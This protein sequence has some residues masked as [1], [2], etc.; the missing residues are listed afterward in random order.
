MIKFIRDY[1]GKAT[2]ERFFVAG[3][4]T[5]EFNAET[6]KYLIEVEAAEKVTPKKSTAKKN[7][8]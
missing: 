6:E 1:R 8:D 4:E 3:V 5:D 7:G 2:D